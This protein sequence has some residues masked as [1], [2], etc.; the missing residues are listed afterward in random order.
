MSRDRQ[1]IL[2]VL[3]DDLGWA[4][5]GYHG[6]VIRTPNIDRMAATG[7]ELDQNYVNPM[8]TPTRASLLT[9]RYPGRFGVQASIRGAI[10]F[11]AI[12]MAP[13]FS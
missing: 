10:P 13:E 7:V 5:V 8:C 12:W 3:A 9:G 6:S 11:F 4:D 2:F 1:N